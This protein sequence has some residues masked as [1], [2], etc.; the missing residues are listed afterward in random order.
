MAELTI[1]PIA[2]DMETAAAMLGKIGRSTFLEKVSRGELP[3]PRKIGGRSMWL[4]EELQ[5]AARDL[6]VSDSRPLP[7]PV[8]VA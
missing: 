7:K 8:K 6:P 3:K 2:V 5:Q 4:V 1:A